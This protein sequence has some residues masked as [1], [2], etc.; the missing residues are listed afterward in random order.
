[1][2]HQH[3]TTSV[4]EPDLIVPRG[5]SGTA[6]SPPGN[7]FPYSTNVSNAHGTSGWIVS[8]TNSGGPPTHGDIH[9]PTASVPPIV[10]KAA[11][12]SAID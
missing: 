9:G 12:C 1:V 8:T 5:L 2:D 11:A 6:L 10:V 7:V 3:L 4:D